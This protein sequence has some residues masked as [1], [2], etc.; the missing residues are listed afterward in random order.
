MS[1]I[2][3]DD[4]LNMV[5]QYNYEELAVVKKL[6]SMLKISIKARKDKVEKTI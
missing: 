6:M 5:K 3:I 4:L 2:T 1:T